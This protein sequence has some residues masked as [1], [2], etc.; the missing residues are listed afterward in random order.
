MLATRGPIHAPA[1]VAWRLLID[2]HEWPHWGPSV[3]AVDCPTRL[4]GPGT[5]GRVQ[6]APGLW[7]QRIT[8][9]PPSDEQ[10]AVPIHALAGAMPLEESQ[11]G[12]AVIA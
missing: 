5:R 3:T 11:G 4:I 2:T 12:V 6:T 7:L 10:T 9:Q 1:L 8:T